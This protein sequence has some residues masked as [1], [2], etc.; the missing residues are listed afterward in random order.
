MPWD[1]FRVILWRIGPDRIAAM[2]ALHDVLGCDLGDAKAALE[3]LPR[4]LLADVSEEH[5]R[6]AA[7]ALARAGCEAEVVLPAQR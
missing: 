4:E 3:D 6:R 2:K 5:A 1:R 7:D